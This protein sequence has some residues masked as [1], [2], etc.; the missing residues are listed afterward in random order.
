[1]PKVNQQGEVIAR[2]EI[3]RRL[4]GVDAIAAMERAFVAYSTG[5]SVVPP[6]GEL[7]FNDPKGE[8]HIK[9]GLDRLGTSWETRSSRIISE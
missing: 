3:E 8:A 5:K 9:Y 7:L 1:M 2:D 4:K 6:V